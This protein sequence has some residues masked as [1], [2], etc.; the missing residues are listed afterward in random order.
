MWNHQHMVSD[1]VHQKCGINGSG[2][3]YIRNVSQGNLLPRSRLTVARGSRGVVL[4]SQEALA[5]GISQEASRG[6]VLRSQEAL[7]LSMSMNLV[8]FGEIVSPPPPSK[9]STEQATICVKAS[10]TH[11]ICYHLI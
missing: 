8:V 9:L 10:D 11:I 6:V 5:T 7:A 4:R 3:L 1:V 2:V